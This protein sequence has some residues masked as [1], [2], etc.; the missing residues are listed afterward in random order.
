MM[1]P[2]P[3]PT[4]ETEHY[5]QGCAENELRFQYCPDC[6][7]A[8]FPP[9]IRCHICHQQSLEWRTSSKRGVVHSATTVI[10]APSKAFKGSTP[11]VI[12]LVDLDEGFRIMTNIT[13]ADGSEVDIGKP[14]RNIFE[15]AADTIALPQAELVYEN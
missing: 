12:A 13:N 15:P 8:Q 1:K 2:L 3:K 7:Q 5:W 10:R 9:R 4:G 11:Y 14:V 6:E